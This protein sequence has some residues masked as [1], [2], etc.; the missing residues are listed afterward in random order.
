[1]I[2][3]ESVRERSRN[4]KDLLAL[5]AEEPPCRYRLMLHSLL[6]DAELLI[7]EIDALRS[8]CSHTHLIQ[9]FSEAGEPTASYSC[10]NCHQTF[11]KDRPLPEPD[12]F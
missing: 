11:S 10:V 12:N 7:R 2:D 5:V 6:D 1:M 3:L 9:R 8:L 4:L